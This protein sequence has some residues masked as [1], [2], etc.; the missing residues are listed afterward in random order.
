M[1]EREV[2]DDY[3]NALAETGR[4]IQ[5][6][7][8]MAKNAWK[9]YRQ[10]GFDKTQWLEIQGTLAMELH[11]VTFGTIGMLSRAWRANAP[12][13]QPTPEREPGEGA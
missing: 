5:R 4:L 12:E 10:G 8:R 13:W 11:D 6:A 7:E 1:T 3:M 9:V 2:F